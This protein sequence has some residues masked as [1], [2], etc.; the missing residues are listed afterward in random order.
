MKISIIGAGN[1]GGLAA[2]RIAQEG[3]GDIVLIDVVKGLAEGKVLDLEDASSFL[4]YNYTI[5]GTDDI[6]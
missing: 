6:F 3:L 5:E 1:V 2:L 4:K